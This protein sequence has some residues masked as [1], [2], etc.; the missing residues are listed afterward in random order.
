MDNSNY[1]MPDASEAVTVKIADFR[2]AIEH[3]ERKLH[4]DYHACV[5]AAERAAWAAQARRV[6]SELIRLVC[7]RAT[8]DDMDR[9]ERAL[10]RSTA[11]IAKV[12]QAG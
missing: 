4:V 7:K 10:D 12:L 8:A 6:G 11:L 2:R 9:R 5:G 1:T 3:L